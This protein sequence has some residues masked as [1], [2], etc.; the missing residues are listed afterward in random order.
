M[1]CRPA[2]GLL[3]D[4]DEVMDAKWLFHA[5]RAR[6]AQRRS[7]FLVGNVAGDEDQARG[8]FRAIG[9]DPGIDLGAIDAA[10]EC[11]CRRRRRENRRFPAGAGLQ[12]RIRSAH[13]G[14]AMALQ[15]GAH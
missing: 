9:G 7:G 1:R 8:E 6:A 4:G 11:A 14:V 10:R 13:D 12:R 15:N 5:G 3:D 2:H